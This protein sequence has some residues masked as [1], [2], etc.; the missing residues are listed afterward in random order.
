MN[1]FRNRAANEPV[2]MLKEHLA[3][4]QDLLS[5]LALHVLGD[6][7]SMPALKQGLSLVRQLSNDSSDRLFHSRSTDRSTNQVWESLNVSH[8]RLV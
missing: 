2:P 6:R 8:R 5:E 4:E 1:E 7:S 3:F